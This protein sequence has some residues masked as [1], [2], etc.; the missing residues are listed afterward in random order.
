V[1]LGHTIDASGTIAV[2]GTAQV[3][4]AANPARKY[5]FIQNPILATE[6][7]RFCPDVTSTTTNSFELAPGASFSFFED[8]FLPTGAISILAATGAHA[9]IAKWA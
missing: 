8:G 6:T 5:L 4:L 2:G 9:F 7:L 1:S 3:L